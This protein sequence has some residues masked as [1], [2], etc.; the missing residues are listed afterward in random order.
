MSGSKERI[1]AA[2][3]MKCGFCMSV[4]PVYQED[5]VESH[6]ARGR[7]L[8]IRLA[9][10]EKVPDPDTYA[11]SLDICLLCGRCQAVCPAGVPSPAINVQ[12]RHARLATQGLSLRQRLVYRGMVKH[13]SLMARMLGLAALIPGLNHNDGV[14]IR[15]MA[16]ATTLFSGGLFLPGIS[17]PFLSKRLSRPVAPPQGRPASGRVAYFPGCGF[18]FFFSQTGYDIAHALA[19]AGVEVVCPDNLTCCGMAV[20]NAGDG[21]TA[22]ELAA[23]NIEALLPYDHVI[24]GCATCGS[25][26]KRYGQWFESDKRM[27][28]KARDFS[29]KVSDFSQFLVSQDFQPVR[30]GAAPVKITYHEPCHLKWYQ[31]VGDFP[32]QLLQ[33]LDGVELIEMENADACCGLGG[34]FGIH[35]REISRSIQ[36]KKIRAIEKTGADIVATACPGCMIQLMDGIRRHGLPMDVVHVGQLL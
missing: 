17:R 31:G 25:T 29:E 30:N 36:E 32:R 1:G 19:L 14:P 23:Q 9:E 16:D 35:H 28:S 4:C 12:A 22:R 20:Y 18:E 8:L 10:E 34:A 15:H 5:R 21:K 2:R 11:S 3:C 6:V 24:T 33:A 13:R 26:L 7:N 27:K